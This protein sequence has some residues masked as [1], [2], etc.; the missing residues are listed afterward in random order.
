ML[1]WGIMNLYCILDYLL[2][3]I[4]YFNPFTYMRIFVED[5]YA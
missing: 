2:D 4:I 5:V 3:T 1:T